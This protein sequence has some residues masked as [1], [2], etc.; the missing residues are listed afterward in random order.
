MDIGGKILEPDAAME[1]A[2]KIG[3]DKFPSYPTVEEADARYQQIHQFMEQ[4]Q[5]TMMGA[6]KVRTM[7]AKRRNETIVGGD[8]G[9]ATI[10]GDY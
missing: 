6:G 2:S 9:G 3:L 7:A 8:P 10:I 5:P 1:H 4:E